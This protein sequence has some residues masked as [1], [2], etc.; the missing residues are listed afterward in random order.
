MLDFVEGTGRKA[1]VWGSFT[2][3]SQGEDIDAE[4]VEI[5]LWN[6]GYANMDQMYEDGFDLI[7]CKMEIIILF[8][9]LVITMTI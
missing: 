6:F 3:A 4:G 7:N 9:M 8:Q 1:R 5:N 2:Q